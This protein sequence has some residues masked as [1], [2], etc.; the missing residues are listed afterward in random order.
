MS[1]L[2]VPINTIPYLMPNP[3]RATSMS[4]PSRHGLLARRVRAALVFVEPLYC[5][6]NVIGSSRHG[7]LRQYRDSHRLVVVSER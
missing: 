7:R 5:L 4:R 3:M 6:A 2:A 1:G